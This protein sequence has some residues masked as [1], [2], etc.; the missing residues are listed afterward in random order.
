[1]PKLKDFANILN[2]IL[3]TCPE[4]A[5]AEVM[6]NS[7]EDKLDSIKAVTQ[8]TRASGGVAVVLHTI[9]HDDINEG[10]AILDQVGN[11]K[12]N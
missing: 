12:S 1:M 9:M 2:N 10:E 5:D 6:V 11:I 7:E 8:V 4:L 3:A